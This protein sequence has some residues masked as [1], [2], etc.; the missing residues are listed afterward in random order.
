MAKRA[1][2]GKSRG[3]PRCAP[4]WPELARKKKKAPPKEVPAIWSRAREDILAAIGADYVRSTLHP[5]GTDPP[6]DFTLRMI[7][8]GLSAQERYISDFIDMDIARAIDH[9]D[10]LPAGTITPQHLLLAVAAHRGFELRSVSNPLIA[11][12]QM[13]KLLDDYMKA[14]S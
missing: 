11:Y 7:E 3:T 12:R 8:H 6:A 4:G 2:I 1:K 9:F 14:L 5:L 10:Q 13:K